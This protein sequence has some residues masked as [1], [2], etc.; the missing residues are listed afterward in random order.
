V[1]A[2]GQTITLP[3]GS[4][5]VYVVGAST[6][7]DQNAA[8]RAGDKSF[9]VLIQN[10]GGF[11]GQWDDRQWKTREVVIPPRTPPPGTPPDIAAQLQRPRTRT[12]PYGEMIGITPGFIKRS[13]L[14]WFAS[15]RHTADGANEYYAYSYLFAY[16]IDLPPNAKT[17]TL[18]NNDKIR[19][20][21]IT[22]A[23]QRGQVRPAQPLYDTLERVSR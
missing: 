6:D 1:I 18:P 3:A 14:A 15:H 20:L 5:R 12:D 7:G 16:A 9:D 13:P 2:K 11:I 19:V 8:F 22:A 10:W 21:A 4:N 23:N 17:L